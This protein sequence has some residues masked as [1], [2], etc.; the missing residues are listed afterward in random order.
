MNKNEGSSWK[1]TLDSGA[2]KY[3]CFLPLAVIAGP[4]LE[5]GQ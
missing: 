4:G 2:Q 1:N 3:V 5:E